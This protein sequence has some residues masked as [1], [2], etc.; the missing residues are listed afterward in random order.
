MTVAVLCQW[1]L[2]GSASKDCH[3]AFLMQSYA[4]SVGERGGG[5]VITELE[6]TDS[7]DKT[8]VSASDPAT[9]VLAN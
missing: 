6:I 2:Y 1:A 7:S 9:L 4:I 8:S 3:P 5:T